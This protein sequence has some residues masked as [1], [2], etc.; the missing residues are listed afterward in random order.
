MTDG[1]SPIATPEE[2]RLR[3]RLSDCFDKYDFDLRRLEL[4][5]ADE[6]SPPPSGRALINEAEVRACIL[7]PILNVLGWD[8]SS[9]LNIA[10][11]DP[12]APRIATPEEK[13]R[14]LDYHGRAIAE[15]SSSK[16]LLLVEAKRASI[17]LPD[18][19]AGAVATHEFATAISGILSGTKGKTKSETFELTATW[20]KFI[21]TLCDYV[22]R[23]HEKTKGSP[24]TA[25]ISNGDWFVVFINPQ[26]TFID[27][28]PIA[29][30]IQIYQ[31]RHDVLAATARFSEY[32]G[33]SSLANHIPDQKPDALMNFVR[34]RTDKV[35]AIFG[36]RLSY[37]KHGLPSQSQPAIGVYVYVRVRTPNGALITFYEDDNFIPFRS[38]ADEI[39]ELRQEISTKSSALLT[40]MRRHADISILSIEDWINARKDSLCKSA[41][42][43]T[44]NFDILTGSAEFFI[45][46][47]VS[48]NTCSYHDSG[49]CAA[50]HKL[51]PIG[52]VLRSQVSPRVFFPSGSPLHCSHIAVHALR[53]K[54]RCLIS[55]FEQSLCCRRCVFFNICYREEEQKKLLP[56]KKN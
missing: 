16:S 11:E 13:V 49:K 30:D 29:A 37:A 56:C 27:L 12:I 45:N 31:N 17:S 1:G 15:D 54:I 21:S 41:P 39:E 6:D 7:D 35:E 23:V 18:F 3:N 10:V 26:R 44:N 42:G 25:V 55:G 51:S 47:D 52:P 5:N 48:W 9:T 46:T 4:L 8:T 50:A 33:Y 24:T 19:S 53:E 32:L 40:E 34:D 43:D 22:C 14:F 36:V 20:E 28:D 38:D 2:N